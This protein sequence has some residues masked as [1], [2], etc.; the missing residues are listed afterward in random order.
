MT[1]EGFLEAVAAALGDEAF[2]LALRAGLAE[3]VSAGLIEARR[4][5]PEAP[6]ADE[7]FAGYLAARLAHQASLHEAARRLRI[8]ELFL[9]WWAGSGDRLGIVAFES[10][11]ADDLGRLVARFAE[12]PAEEQR[13]RLRIKLFIGTGSAVPRIRDYSGQEALQA[14]LRVTASRALVDAT[15]GDA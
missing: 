7:H 6:I 9:A 13:Q 5:W 14:W 4:R 10:T 12:R 15:R 2:E 11:F 1:E 8:E 3:R